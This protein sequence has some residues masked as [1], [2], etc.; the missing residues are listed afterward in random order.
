MEIKTELE[1]I[2]IQIL[3]SLIPFYGKDKSEV[4]KNIVLRW[5]EENIGTE[6]IIKMNEIGAINM[7]NKH[8]KT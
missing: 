2:H 4:L 3:E 5:I 8:V 7:R 6:K 1:E